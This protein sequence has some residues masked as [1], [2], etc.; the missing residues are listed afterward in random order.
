M[1]LLEYNPCHVK[2]A[3][4]ELEEKCHAAMLYD[5]MDLSR[6][7]FH[8]QQVEESHLRK[9]NREVKKKNCFSGSSSKSRFDV[10]QNTKFKKRFQK[11]FLVISL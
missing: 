1:C 7:I 8:V 10:Q 5:N 3:S 4:E 6:L 11:K 2:G 9:T